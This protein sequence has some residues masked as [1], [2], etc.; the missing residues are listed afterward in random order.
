MRLTTQAKQLAAVVQL[1]KQMQH[2]VRMLEQI[3]GQ[4]GVCEREL[5]QMYNIIVE[6]TGD[7]Q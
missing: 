2:M 6:D 1:A 5:E 3:A 4:V 7:E